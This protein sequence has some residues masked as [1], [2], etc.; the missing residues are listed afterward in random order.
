MGDDIA[1]VKPFYGGGFTVETI[2]TARAAVAR[3][4]SYVSEMVAG[5]RKNSTNTPMI[6]ALIDADKGT[7]LTHQKCARSGV[8]AGAGSLAAAYFHLRCGRCCQRVRDC[9]TCYVHASP[10]NP[11]STITRASAAGSNQRE[12]AGVGV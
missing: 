9:P 5:P 4:K 6:T 10:S 1:A 3:M 11:S 12:G 8:S 2:R 7:A